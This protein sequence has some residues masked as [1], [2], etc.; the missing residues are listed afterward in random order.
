MNE[1]SDKSRA[2]G[3]GRYRRKTEWKTDSVEAVALINSVT[4][5]NKKSKG[6]LQFYE[7][8]GRMVLINEGQSL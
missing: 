1:Q 7:K 5:E 6:T 2:K 8:G 3:M 4:V